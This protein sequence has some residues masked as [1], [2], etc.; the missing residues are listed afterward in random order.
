M[1]KGEQMHIIHDTNEG[2]MRSL[3]FHPLSLMH[4]IAIGLASAK[5]L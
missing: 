4:V 1:V 5:P 3:S 2:S